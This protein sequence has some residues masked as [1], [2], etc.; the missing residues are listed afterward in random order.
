LT[1]HADRGSSMTSKPIAFLLADLGV[2]QSHSRPHV[3]DDNPYSEAQFKTLKYRP[4]FPGRFGSIEAARLHC[5]EFFAWYNDEHR[6]SGLGL[7]TPADVHYGLA[8]VVR[9]KR[10]AILDA[11][12]AAHPRTVPPQTPRTAETAHRLVDQSTRPAGRRAHRGDF[13]RGD[14]VIRLA[15]SAARVGGQA[16]ACPRRGSVRC[17]RGSGV[18]GGRRSSRSDRAAT[19]DAG[20]AAPYPRAARQP[21]LPNSRRL[22]DTGPRPLSVRSNRTSVASLPPPWDWEDPAQ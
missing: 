6:H 11:A 13:R 4:N 15:A 20:G 12:Y 16:V 22:L 8:E 3:S 1:I 17:R 9:D 14:L 21:E 10:A 18:Q 2:T 19:L 7:H 5:Q